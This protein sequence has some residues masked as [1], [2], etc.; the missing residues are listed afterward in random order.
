MKKIR[1]KICNR[2]FF[3]LYTHF[4]KHGLTREHYLKRFPKAEVDSE[5]YRQFR[6]KSLFQFYH[7]NP[8]VKSKYYAKHPETVEKIRRSVNKKYKQHPE[9]IKQISES[10]K[11]VLSAPKMR[12]KLSRIKKKFHREY[13]RA[14]KQH[15]KRM[16]ELYKKHPELGKHHGQVMRELF[17]KN[18]KKR[19]EYSNIQKK[20]H[21]MHPEYW[22]KMGETRKVYFEKHPEWG[23]MMSK[24]KKQFY[25]K[26]PEKL[27][28][29][30]EAAKKVIKPHIK[31]KQGFLVRSKGEKKIA[32]Y[33]YSHKIKFGYE[34]LLSFEEGVVFPDF[35]LP[36]YKLYV[37]Y[38]GQFRNKGKGLSERTKEKM[39]IYKTHR[40]KV[41]NL[42]PQDLKNLDN[43]LL[44]KLKK[45]YK[46][47]KNQLFLNSLI[48]K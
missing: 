47:K 36:K 24:I 9:I 5:D 11:K 20:I 33:L 29:L 37:E 19:E 38:Y 39:R 17:E 46:H 26:H 1:C 43:C 18:P 2:T 7:K 48:T 41:I 42:F 16:E 10:T 27:L 32:D 28:K 34:D 3:N 30:I 13:P 8:G 15:G 6:S 45:N 21:K 44:K 14:G 31:T 12:K 4:H 40:K 25:K 35:Y 23:E 22:E